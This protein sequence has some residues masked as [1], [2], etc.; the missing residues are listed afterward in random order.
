MEV[1]YTAE[2]ERDYV[3]ASVMTAIQIEVY[4][5]PGDILMFLTGE[6]EINDAGSSLRRETGSF[7]PEKQQLVVVPLYS[8]LPPQQQADAFQPTPAG[9]RKIVVSTNIAETSVTINGVVFVIDCGFCKQKV[10]DPK[11]R[12]E[13]LVVT[14]ISQ[15]SAKQRAGRAGRTQPGN[16]LRLFTEHSFN[17]QLPVAHALCLHRRNKPRPRSFAVTS[18]PSSSR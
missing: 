3:A 16:S 1:C 8:S 13:S 6:Q 17:T 18:H 15:A 2:P 12:I 11:S 7:P 10:F 9:C 14:P 4:E 5:G